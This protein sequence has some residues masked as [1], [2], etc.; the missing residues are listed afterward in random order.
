M[1]FVLTRELRVA[2]RLDVKRTG[3]ALV[4]HAV[5]L[6]AGGSCLATRGVKQWVSAHRP[7]QKTGPRRYL[8][9]PARGLRRHRIDSYGRGAS[10]AD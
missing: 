3:K 6:S 2:D 9:E 4:D 10:K 8:S 7:P 5:S 1:R